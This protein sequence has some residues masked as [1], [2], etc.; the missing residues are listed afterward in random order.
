MEVSRVTHAI[1]NVVFTCVGNDENHE[2]GAFGRY[3]I[4]KADVQQHIPDNVTFEEACAAGVGLVTVGYALYKLLDLP[5]PK[6]HPTPIK[7]DILIYGGSTA[8]GTVA[9]QFAK[10]S[11]ALISFEYDPLAKFKTGLVCES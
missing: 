7:K 2:T 3:I 8:A 6:M 1:V 10:L 4:V 5:P 11:S 9:I